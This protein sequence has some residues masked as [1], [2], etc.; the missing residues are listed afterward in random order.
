[1]GGP[2]GA[3]KLGFETTYWLDT[4]SKDIRED[5]NQLPDH[6]KVA[7]IT[8]NYSYYH[9]LQ[10]QGLFKEKLYF[11]PQNPD[12]VL[13]VPHQGKFDSFA[14]DLYKNKDPIYS[15]KLNDQPVALIYQINFK[16]SP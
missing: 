4:L 8:G 16:K 3:A 12:F 14:W 2:K 7:V 5:I 10:K 13:D 1:V 11:T 9:N 6:Y 15:A